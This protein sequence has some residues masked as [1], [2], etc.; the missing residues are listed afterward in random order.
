MHVSIDVSEEDLD[1]DYSMVPG[2]V[3]ACIRS[4]FLVPKET[5]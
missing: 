2:L 3:I 1:G 5:P 4:R